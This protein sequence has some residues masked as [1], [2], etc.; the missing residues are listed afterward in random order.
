MKKNE[1]GLKYIATARTSVNYI[2]SYTYDIH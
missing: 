2:Y 1:M